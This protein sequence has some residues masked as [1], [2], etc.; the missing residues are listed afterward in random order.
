MAKYISRVDI[1]TCAIIEKAVE[2]WRMLVKTDR[3]GVV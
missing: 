1:L 2:D 3:A